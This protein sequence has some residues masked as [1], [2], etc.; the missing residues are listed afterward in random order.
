MLIGSKKIITSNQAIAWTSNPIY[1]GQ[2]INF[3]IQMNYLSTGCTIKLQ[4]SCDS[5]S[6][7]DTVSPNNYANIV[8]W[9]DI[10]DSITTIT[11]NGDLL[12]DIK[13]VPYIW[14][15]IVTTGTGTITSATFNTK[16]F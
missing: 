4:G 1:I 5:G 14:V 9:S 13:E 10:Y 11:E 7:L 2:V 3:A 15:R 6:P 16:G 8:N 12:F